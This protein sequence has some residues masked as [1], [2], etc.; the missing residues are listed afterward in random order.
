M[1]LQGG[2][3]G[4]EAGG[5]DMVQRISA[6]L[7]AVNDKVGD[8]AFDMEEIQGSVT[9]DE[10]GPFQNVF[11]QECDRVEALLTEIKSSVKELEMGLS[12]ELTMS[13]R[14]EKLQRALYLDRVPETWSK[15]AYP[16]LRTL[17]SWLE[18]LV[19]RVNQLQSWVDNPTSIPNVVD[20]SLLFNPQ[21]FLTAVMQVT[22]QRNNLEL[23]KLAIVTDVTRKQVDEIDGPARDGAYI[24]GLNLEGNRWNP[25]AGLLEESLPREM[26]C[27]MPVINVKAV[28]AE[29]METAGVHQCPVYQTQQRGPTYVF[30][31]L[32]RTRQPPEKWV[33]AGVALF[34]DINQ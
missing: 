26:F 31:A 15:I 3:G 7:E 13:E 27:P 4:G 22:A 5:Q 30:N 17:S 24:T 6:I 12:G 25:Q 21:S 14:M 29:K 32:L 9:Q 10:R 20:V 19:V 8:L 1:A 23:D 34:M 11:I 16:S 28:L 18:D 33:L 2:G